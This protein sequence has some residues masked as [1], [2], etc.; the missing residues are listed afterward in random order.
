MTQ[1]VTQGMEQAAGAPA[2]DRPRVLYL[3]KVYPYPPATAGDAVYSR[4]IIEAVS[5]TCEVTVLCAGSGAERRDPAGIDWHV[6]GPQRRGRAGSV[7]S[8]LPLIAWKGATADFTARLKQLLQQNWDAIVLDNLGL[9]HAL[10]AALDYRARNPGTKL[11]YISHE[12]ELPTRSAKYGSYDL[13][14]PKRIMATRDLAKVQ[15]AEEALLRHC[16]IVTVINTA[17]LVPFRKIGGGRKYLDLSP[18]YNGPVV[19]SRRI[20]KETPRRILLLGGRRSEQKR[21]ILLDWMAA[22]YGRLC[23]AGIEMVIAGDMEESLR[24]RLRR[25][26]P[27]AQTL[28]FVED[29]EALI[30]SGRMGVIADTVGGG[31]KMRLLSHVFERLPMVGLDG[32]ISGLPTPEGRG[33]L[34]SPGLEALV[35]LVCK[36]IDDAD[37]LNGLH[38]AAFDDCI[39]AY[40]WQTRAEAFA[41]ALGPDAGSVLV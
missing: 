14:L 17:D 16:D 18:G 39:A 25:D 12:Y 9:A 4:G 35:D 3:T 40:S 8:A 41:R 6:T 23:A 2:R 27:K 33:Y 36:I 31:F 10:P 15:R 7:L 19:A 22:A 21:Q 28:G 38:D 30:A 37:L 34:A 24:E 20:T 32:A 13:S 29:L 1:A 5:Q 11:V 26:Y